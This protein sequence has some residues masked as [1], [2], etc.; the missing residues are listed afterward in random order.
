MMPSNGLTD[1]PPRLFWMS[2]RRPPLA[3]DERTRFFAELER[4]ATSW[5]AVKLSRLTDVKWFHPKLTIEVKHLA[6]SKT[7]RHVTVKRLSSCCR[8]EVFP[9][10]G[11]SRQYPVAF[12]S[13]TP[14]A[15]LPNLVAKGD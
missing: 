12:K 1:G 14:T 6:G 5:A 13:A 15:K 10:L 3:G 11:Q 4:L 9:H 2:S 8:Y 7:L